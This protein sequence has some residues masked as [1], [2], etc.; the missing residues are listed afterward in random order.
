[1]TNK[2]LSKFINNLKFNTFIKDDIETCAMK[3]YI[4]K[5]LFIGNTVSNSRHVI[6]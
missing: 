6:R 2:N 3:L 5:L 1:M 4:F